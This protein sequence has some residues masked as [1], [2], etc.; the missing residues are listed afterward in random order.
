MKVQKNLSLDLDV[1]QKLD[2]EENQ[3]EL[4][5]RLLREHYGMNDE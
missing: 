5:Q 3:T 4:V 2:D 1:A